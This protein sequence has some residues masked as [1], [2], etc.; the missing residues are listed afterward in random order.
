MTDDSSG[1]TTYVLAS[2]IVPA[3]VPLKL[4]IWD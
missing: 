3:F 2:V 1:V 4:E